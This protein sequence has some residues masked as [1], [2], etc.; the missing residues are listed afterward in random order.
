MCLLYH[1]LPFDKSFISTNFGKIRFIIHDADL[2]SLTCREVLRYCLE[3]CGGIG[4][5][6]TEEKFVIRWFSN[7]N[8]KE[9][10]TNNFISYSSDEEDIEFNNVRFSRGNVTYDSNS[11]YSNIKGTIYITSDNPLLEH[12]TSTKIKSLIEN[13]NVKHLSYFSCKVQ[14]SSIEKYSL[15]DCLSFSDENGNEKIMLVSNITIK[16]LSNVTVESL[17]IDTTVSESDES[18]TDAGAGSQSYNFNIKGITDRVDVQFSECNKNTKIFVSCTMT[19]TK[20]SGNITFSFDNKIIRTYTP[21]LGTNTFSFIID[22]VDQLE[23]IMKFSTGSTYSY[24]EYNFIYCNCLIVDYSEEDDPDT[25][26]EGIDAT[27]GY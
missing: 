2:S 10:D 19:F 9:I 23:N 17:G 24:F 8:V 5:L 16:N 4:I 3:I 14:I 15:G 6:N 13:L 27:G 12:S 7:N 1:V 21:I 26:Y 22:G 11:D 25:S 20:I 18:E